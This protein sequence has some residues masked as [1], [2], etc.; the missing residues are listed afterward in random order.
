[1]GARGALLTER[2]AAGCVLRQERAAGA[3][4]KWHHSGSQAARGGEKAFLLR[5]LLCSK[6]SDHV[7]SVRH[8]GAGGASQS[9]VW[10]SKQQA[11]MH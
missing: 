4:I 1:M 6:E 8:S 9:L 11:L 10:Y 5:R 3:A 2:A 7:Q